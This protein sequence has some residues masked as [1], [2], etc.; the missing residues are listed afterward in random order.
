[1]NTVE[2]ADSFLQLA[3][4]HQWPGVATWTWHPQG[5]GPNHIAA[6]LTTA[7]AQQ[8]RTLLN[9]RQIDLVM[10]HFAHHNI[11]S[12]GNFL[13]TP[14]TANA[15]NSYKTLQRFGCLRTGAI[16]IPHYQQDYLNHLSGSWATLAI[17]SHPLERAYEAFYKL[18]QL[19]SKSSSRVKLSF[20]GWLHYTPDACGKGPP[21]PTL[22]Q[23]GTASSPPFW[24]A[25][26]QGM[27]ADRPVIKLPVVKKS[28]VVVDG[29]LP[30]GSSQKTVSSPSRL[31]SRTHDSVKIAAA[32]SSRLTPQ[33]SSSPTAAALT[34]SSPD[35]STKQRVENTEAKCNRN[36]EN[37]GDRAMME[38]LARLRK[39]KE[40]TDA[41]LARLK[42]Q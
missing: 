13:G 7:G 32:D 5:T 37:V 4:K 39:E 2:A 3:L 18:Q 33:R 12:I 19:V 26:S 28:K 42:V 24:G 21:K 20:T 9:D 38:E 15:D 17:G 41:E 14:P 16:V 40:E 35:A 22:L 31:R 34:A 1:M 25:S 27:S 29:S 23:K 10:F 6:D 36:G 11:R 8:A 30:G